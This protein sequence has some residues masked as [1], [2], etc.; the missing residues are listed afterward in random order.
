MPKFVADSSTATGLAYAAPSSGALTFIT[1]ATFSTVASVSLPNDTFTSTYDNYKVILN[2][3]GSSGV[4][5][6]AV[7]YRASGS[8]NTTSEY[9]Q[10]GAQQNGAG[11]ASNIGASGLTSFQWGNID[12]GNASNTQYH[13]TVMSPKLAQ[14][15]STLVHGTFSTQS[16]ATLGL[17]F[18][19]TT[20]FDAM[21]FF[22]TTG[23]F[24]GTYRVYGIVNS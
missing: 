7:R 8:D 16:T 20:S 13:F 6:F 4:V 19:A 11:G 5:D 9:R 14:Y 2:V 18:L 12:S 21:S 15:T 1:G 17:M 3:T 22:V 10:A 24:S 23:T